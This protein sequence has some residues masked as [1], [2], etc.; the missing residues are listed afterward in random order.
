MPQRQAGFGLSA[1]NTVDGYAQHLAHIGRNIQ[2]K[3]QDGDHD[4]RR[5]QRRHEYIVH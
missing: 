1:V 4:A 3:G 2:G 5:P